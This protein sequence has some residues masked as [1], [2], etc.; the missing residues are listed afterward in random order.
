MLDINFKQIYLFN[1]NVRFCVLN[2]ALIIIECFFLAT[3]FEQS[4]DLSDTT[5]NMASRAPFFIIAII[6][7]IILYT[8]L[9]LYLEIRHKRLKNISKVFN[10][11]LNSNDEKSSNSASAYSLK[12]SNLQQDYSSEK[13]KSNEKPKTPKEKEKVK[14]SNFIKPF[15]RERPPR[16]NRKAERADEQSQSSDYG[17]GN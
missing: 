15:N 7:F 4:S 16:R 10:D 14:S 17:N 8:I 13:D 9:F 2:I 6:F 1:H 5:F 3:S 11:M 12:K